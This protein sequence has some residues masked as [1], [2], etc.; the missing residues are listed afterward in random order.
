[1]GNVCCENTDPTKGYEPYPVKELDFEAATDFKPNLS[2]IIN[3][4]IDEWKKSI[5]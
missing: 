1:M 3:D 5:Q 2:K 4:K